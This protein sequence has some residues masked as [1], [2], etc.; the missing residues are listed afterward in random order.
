[1]A[2]K[3]PPSSS[4][5]KP[6]INPIME[7]LSFLFI[8]SKILGM[9]P[10]SFSDYITKKQFK[11]SQFGNIFCVLSCIHYAIHYHI[12][13]DATMMAKD[14]E[15]SIGTLTMVIGVFI[16]YMEPLMMAIDV[17]ASLINQKSLMTIF[18]RLG[19]VDDKLFKE[20]ILLNYGVV[21]KYSIIF[22]TIAFIGEGS[23]GLFNLIVFSDNFFSWHSLWW[24]IGCIPL[25][26]NWIAKTWFL[27]LILLVQQ[28]L[29][30][31]NN[32]LN[33]TKNVFLERKKRHGNALG[34]N[35]KKD[36]LFMENIGYLEK[37]IFS[38]RNM[39]IKSDNARNWVG[40][41]IMTNKVNDVN[42]FAPKSKEIISVSPYDPNRKGE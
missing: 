10:Y 26:N 29:R 6:P 39:K 34:L 38:T 24:L 22:L 13:T 32:Y 31:I 18:E 21:K 25:F 14:A 28:R 41:S 15:S 35:F 17:I 40:S 36:N 2:E 19:E 11:L 30:A 9:I 8:V 27:L 16:I 3:K 33:D 7:S 5:K 20:N 23:L 37:E 1:M 42:I 12:L 4:G